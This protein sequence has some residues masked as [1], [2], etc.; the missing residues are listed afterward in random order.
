M[1]DGLE[2]TEE[3]DGR[4][5]VRLLH[6]EDGKEQIKCPSYKRAIRIVKDNQYSV[7]AAKIIDRDGDVVFTSADM[8]IDDWEAE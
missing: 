3:Y 4:I 1:S 6:D 2:A 5:T 7:L 8:D